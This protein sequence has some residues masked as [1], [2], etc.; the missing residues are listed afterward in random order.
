MGKRDGLRQVGCLSCCAAN[1]EQHTAMASVYIETSVISYLVARPSSDVR[2]AA[3]QVA[4]IDWWETRKGSF[5]TYISE[6]VVAEAERGD[7][8]AARQRLDA[9]GDLDRLEVTSS[10]RSLAQALL[11]EGA[12]PGSA[13]V[14]AY[15]IATAAANGMDYL[16]T[17]NCTHIANAARRASIEATCQRHGYVPPVICTP[18]ELMED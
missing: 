6:L 13:E 2:V 10:V 4:T 7:P 17:W 9:I 15:H 16:L 11:N 1:T 8:S 5:D 12:V 3:A 14:D 18:T